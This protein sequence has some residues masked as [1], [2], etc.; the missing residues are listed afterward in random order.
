MTNVHTSRRFLGMG[1][2]VET[3]EACIRYFGSSCYKEALRFCIHREER[4]CV[5]VQI[6]VNR[7]KSLLPATDLH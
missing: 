5:V 2:T 3:I 1:L 4:C 6:K 7:S